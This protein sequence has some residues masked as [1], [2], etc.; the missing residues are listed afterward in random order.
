MRERQTDRQRVCLCVRER[1]RARAR[2]RERVFV[3]VCV[4]E[5]EREVTSRD[6]SDALGS[7]ETVQGY[8]AHKKSP[9]SPKATI[10]P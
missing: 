5:R 9:P 10:G 4:C 8:L 7:R 3:C 6:S 1:E 2:E